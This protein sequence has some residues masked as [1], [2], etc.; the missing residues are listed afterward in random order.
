MHWQ[1]GEN[2][3]IFAS[4][5][6]W[7]L[8]GNRGLSSISLL[9]ENILST[10]SLGLSHSVCPS[11]AMGQQIYEKQ[12]HEENYRCFVCH[13]SLVQVIAASSRDSG[14]MAERIRQ[15][16]C[17]TTLGKA[18]IWHDWIFVGMSAH[19][20]MQGLSNITIPNLMRMKVTVNDRKLS[21]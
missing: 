14:A 7:A 11:I 12:L 16:A 5:V 2:R 8:W 15:F 19:P 1:N 9:P 3:N 10:A 6:L 17:Q 21:I 20:D 13:E 18:W 4:F